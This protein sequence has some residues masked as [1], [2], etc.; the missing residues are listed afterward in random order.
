MGTSGY[1]ASAS[2][3]FGFTLKLCLTDANMSSAFAGR[4]SKSSAASPAAEAPT[5]TDPGST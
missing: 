2:L 5:R 4:V 3:M 1:S